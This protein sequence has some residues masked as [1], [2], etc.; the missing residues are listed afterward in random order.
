MPSLETW[1]QATNVSEDLN[2]TSTLVENRE[3]HAYGQIELMFVSDFNIKFFFPYENIL[4]WKL[5]IIYHYQ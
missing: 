2:F 4:E 3:H 5:K 1:Q